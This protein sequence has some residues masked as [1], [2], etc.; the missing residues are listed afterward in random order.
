MNSRLKPRRMVLRVTARAIHPRCWSQFVF[1]ALLP[2]SAVRQL[3]AAVLDRCWRSYAWRWDRAH[4]PLA[5]DARCNT[6]RLRRREIC[7]HCSCSSFFFLLLTF[8]STHLS[9]T[10]LAVD[11]LRILA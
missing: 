11:A 7:S 5:S 9:A 8:V 3:G 2:V 4:Q 1:L 10:H 6:R